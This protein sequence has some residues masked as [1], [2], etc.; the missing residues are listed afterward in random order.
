MEY[1]L[2]DVFEHL[3]LIMIIRREIIN[4]AISTKHYELMGVLPEYD[5]LQ[6]QFFEF[7]QT[8]VKKL[9]KNDPED[10]NSR[11]LSLE[12]E[13]HHGS[14]IEERKRMESTDIESIGALTNIRSD[15][16]KGAEGSRGSSRGNRVAPLIEEEVKNE[17]QD[18]IVKIEIQE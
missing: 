12:E 2:M 9:V 10:L 6:D 7:M 8:E 13:D 11:T 5:Y 1:Y 3:I 16:A 4:F 17:A 15:G 18:D 14:M